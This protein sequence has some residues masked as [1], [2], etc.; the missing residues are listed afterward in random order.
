MTQQFAAVQTFGKDGFAAALKAFDAT[1]HG[2]QAILAETT[3]YA[4]SSLEQGAATFEKLVGV[5]SLDK[6]IALQTE[7][8]KSAY[9]GFVAYST[10][11]CELYSKL[12]QD[13]LT[14]FGTLR[15]PAQAPV[16]PAKPV[17]P[18]K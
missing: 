18:A 10:K 6:A 3:G 9:A 17:A 12:A 4:K 14:P 8:L 1:A 2:T 11:T 13:S 7:S 16:V 15:S 5:K